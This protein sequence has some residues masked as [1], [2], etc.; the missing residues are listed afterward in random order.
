[1]V[2][3]INASQI[4]QMRQQTQL[5]WNQYFSSIQKIVFSTLEVSGAGR[6]AVFL[7]LVYVIAVQKFRRDRVS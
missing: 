2:R 3:S 1:M 7:S 6:G 4:L 5:M